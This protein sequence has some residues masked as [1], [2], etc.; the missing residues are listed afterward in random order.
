MST[1]TKE[2]VLTNAG[3]ALYAKIQMGDGTIPL[4]I[5]RIVTGAGRSDDPL[6]LAA[7]VDERHEMTITNRKTIGA[8]TTISAKILNTGIESGYPI[9]QIGFYA[10]DPDDGEI[11]YRIFQ[12]EYPNYMPAVSDWGFTYKDDFNFFTGNASEIILNIDPNGLVT[13]EELEFALTELSSTDYPI[14][15]DT[16]PPDLPIGGT[17]IRP[18]RDIITGT[19]LA[20][21]LMMGNLYIS[22]TPPDPWESGVVWAD[23]SEESEGD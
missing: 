19:V 6:S 20:D 14:I 12:P 3:M 4:N 11:L 2:P 5:T 8:R 16:E 23:T 1:A 18:A 7:V 17:W 22:D 21:G 9:S 15:S 10:L 13:H